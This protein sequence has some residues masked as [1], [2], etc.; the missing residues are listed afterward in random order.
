MRVASFIGMRAKSGDLGEDSSSS[1]A[2]VT[3][4]VGKLPRGKAPEVDEICPEMRR[5][6]T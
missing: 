2:E 3:E 4:V 5:L 6:W 1:L